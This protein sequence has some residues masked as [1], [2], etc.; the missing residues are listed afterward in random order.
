MGAKLARESHDPVRSDLMTCPDHMMK[1]RVVARCDAHTT[2]SAAPH[3][4]HQRRIAQRPSIYRGLG[5]SPSGSRE[6]ALDLYPAT[7][8]D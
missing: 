3:S 5:T 4:A 6:R 8:S 1:H 2:T 7:K